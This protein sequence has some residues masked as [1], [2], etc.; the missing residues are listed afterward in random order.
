MKKK[1]SIL[2]YLIPIIAMIIGIISQYSAL[3]ERIV[4]PFYNAQTQKWPFKKR[5]W[6]KKIM[7]DVAQ[8]IVVAFYVIL[9]LIFLFS[10][11]KSSPK[12]L[13]INLGFVL[14]SSIT[15]VTIIAS[16]KGFTH[17]YSPYHLSMFGGD[18]PHI[19]LFDAVPP[20]SRIG[21]AFPGAHSGTAFS[22]LSIYFLCKEL[23]SK[24]TYHVLI[25]VILLGATFS[26]VQQIRG[27]HFFSHGLFSFAI[28]WIVP[29]FYLKIFFN[30]HITDAS[31]NNDISP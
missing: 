11:R 3:D 24:Y 2:M 28:C 17:L 31:A 30:K 29:M 19:L 27:A 7:H 21:K 15:S 10:L 20:N 4:E 8:D 22:L 1:Y 23:N 6:A 25:F 18:M 26:F 16:I 13:K 14:I 5:F 9:F 12:N